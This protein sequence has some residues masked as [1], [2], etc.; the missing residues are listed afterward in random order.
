MSRREGDLVYRKVRA[1]REHGSAWIDPP[2]NSIQIP[3][4][5]VGAFSVL[6]QSREQ[7][8]ADARR[9]LRRAVEA[10][11]AAESSRDVDPTAPI[12]LSGHQ[13]ELFHP[14]VWF[15]NFA[16]FKLAKQ[17]NATPI[18]LIIDNDLC[19]S[20]AIRCPIKTAASDLWPA[21]CAV[22]PVSYDAAADPIPYEERRVLD[23]PRLGSFADRVAKQVRPFVSDPIISATKMWSAVQLAVSDGAK[24]GDA[25][26]AGRRAAERQCGVHNHETPLHRVCETDSF[27]RFAL[28]LMQSARSFSKLHNESLDA[29]RRV[30]RIRSRSHPAPSLTV[31]GD[32]VEIPFWLW[33]K[34]PHPRRPAFVRRR[35]DD[36]VLFAV[37]DPIEI[38]IPDPEAA[39]EAAIAALRKASVQGVRLRPRALTTTMYC[40]LF[41]ADLFLHGIGGAKYD[42]LTDEL[43]RRFWQVTPPPFAT[44]TATVQMPLPL[45]GVDGESIREAEAKLRQFRF[46][47]E[48]AITDANAE[49]GAPTVSDTA[50]LIQEKQTLIAAKP[51]AGQGKPRR[52]R[53]NQINRLLQPAVAEQREIALE[54]RDQSK[55]QARS[56]R[57]LGSREFSF[58]LQSYETLPSLL[59]DLCREPS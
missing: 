7:L 45:F 32:R 4:D 53:L 48:L 52:D 36:L 13:P 22:E 3:R 6:D 46:H 56:D 23:A 8:A 12:L 19:R 24:L 41:L 44:M 29:Y 25:L 14:G 11:Q 15:K 49:P 50:A 5:D 1:P 39:P 35:A 34:G 38:V 51:P 31:S 16:L 9:E 54:R 27:R 18:N 40:R 47:P 57:I 21:G 28:H 59:L 55:R 17:L 43:I 26:A 10:T 2:W 20:T 58:C 30:N 33:R 42:Q 37:D